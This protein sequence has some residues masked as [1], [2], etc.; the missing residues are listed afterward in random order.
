MRAPGT[1]AYM[2]RLMRN[3]DKFRCVVE[4]LEEVMSQ[5]LAREYAARV[6]GIYAR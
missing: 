1:Q 3:Y 5:E 4:M 6:D 2:D